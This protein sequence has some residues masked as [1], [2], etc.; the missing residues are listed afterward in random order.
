METAGNVHHILLGETNDNVILCAPQ[1]M[2]LGTAILTTLHANKNK[3]MFY[4]LDEQMQL[5]GLG[6]STVAPQEQGLAED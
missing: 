5:F 1:L 2:V 6:V 3:S 4:F